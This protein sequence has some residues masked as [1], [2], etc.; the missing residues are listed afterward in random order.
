MQRL[1]TVVCSSKVYDRPGEERKP[2]DGAPR[3][4]GMEPRQ[5][6]PD[7]AS[8]LGSEL[9]P[10]KET[11]GNHFKLFQLVSKVHLH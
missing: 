11:E 10:W 7:S 4:K 1:T 9:F 3:G 8:S 2:K 5:L 6:L